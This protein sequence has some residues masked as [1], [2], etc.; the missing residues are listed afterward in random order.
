MATIITKNKRFTVEFEAL[1]AKG[2]PSHFQSI[3]SLSGKPVSV[4]LPDTRSLRER[5]M[6]RYRDRERTTEQQG[7]YAVYS[8]DGYLLFTDKLASENKLF[9]NWRTGDSRSYTRIPVGRVGF[10][11]YGRRPQPNVSDVAFA[12][13]HFFIA[14]MTDTPPHDLILS[15]ID[16]RTQKR[17]DRVVARGTGYATLISLAHIGNHGLI[18]SHRAVIGDDDAKIDVFPIS[19]QKA[20]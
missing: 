19:L 15:C 1:N 16:P 12:G 5:Y 11:L 2:K 4:R 7:I 8:L 9:L 6:Q 20:A 17:R 14:W 3:Y 18:V 13:G 10:H